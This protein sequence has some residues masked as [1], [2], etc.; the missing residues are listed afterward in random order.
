MNMMQC[1]Q[2]TLK[3]KFETNPNYIEKVIQINVTA[4]R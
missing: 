2:E 4:T 3:V 1:P